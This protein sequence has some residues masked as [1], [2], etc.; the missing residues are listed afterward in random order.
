MRGPDRQT[1]AALAKTERIKNLDTRAFVAEMRR[2]GVTPHVAIRPRLTVWSGGLTRK[3][4]PGNSG[5]CERQ[6]ARD[7]N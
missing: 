3:A 1:S 5:A 7:P 2:L 4:R 6:T